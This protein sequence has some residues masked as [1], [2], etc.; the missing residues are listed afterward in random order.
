MNENLSS[1]QGYTGTGTSSQ[2]GGKSESS[3]SGNSS[4]ESS[5]KDSTNKP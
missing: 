1:N 3:K 2:S 4:Y 5:A